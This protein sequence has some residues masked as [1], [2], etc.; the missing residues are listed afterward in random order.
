MPFDLPT[1]A[2]TVLTACG[3]SAAIAVGVVK[4]FG[5]RWL[6]HRF[7]ARL[8][9]LKHDHQTEVENLRFRIA[10]LLDRSTKL[11]QRE[12]EVLPDVWSKIDDAHHKLRSLIAIFKE[13]PDVGRMADGQFEAFVTGCQL[14]DWQ[15][16]E[17]RAETNRFK[18]T[19]YYSEAIRWIE[20]HQA[21]VAAQ[22][23][24]EAVSKGSIYIHPE[25]Y[26]KVLA[27]ANRIVDVVQTWRINQQIRADGDA[28]SLKKDP[29]DPIQAYRKSGHD[30]FVGLGAYLRARYWTMP[31]TTLAAQTSLLLSA[32]TE[33]L[34]EPS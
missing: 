9:A 19:E 8:E 4:V 23:M 34:S 11:N 31:D 12:F 29:N 32:Q 3:G 2:L 6:E 20:L 17:L 21:L 28:G 14:Q 10:G 18:R 30:E 22:T 26:E 25:T 24:N 16:D 27:C 5:N 33:S 7:N 1:F 13:S 15:K